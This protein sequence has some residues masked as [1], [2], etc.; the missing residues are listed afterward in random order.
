LAAA[1]L[2]I[3]HAHEPHDHRCKNDQMDSHGCRL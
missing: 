1:V 2:R 3:K